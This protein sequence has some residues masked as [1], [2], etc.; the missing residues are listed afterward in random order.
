M[1]NNFQILEL[2]GKSLT[3]QTNKKNCYFPKVG[4]L[5][6]YLTTSFTTFTFLIR[7]RNVAQLL[8]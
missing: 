5:N 8:L 6:F 1:I 7:L 4:E 2:Q 3:K